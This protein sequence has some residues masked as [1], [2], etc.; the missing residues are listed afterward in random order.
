MK[1]KK[2]L[3]VAGLL[4]PTC[5]FIVSCSQS[6]TEQ[7]ANELHFDLREISELTISYDEEPLTFFRSDTGELIIKEYMTESKE[8]YY[9][10]VKQGN[11]SIQISEGGKP[12]FRGGFS[13]YVEVYMP[14]EYHGSLSVTST[15][16]KIDLSGVDL[17]LASLRIDST[18]G[19]VL[20][21][22]ADAADIHLSTTS[23]TLDLGS[24]TGKQI[25]LETTSGLIACTKLNGAVTYT[26]TSGDIDVKSAVGSGTYR[27]NNS[28]KLKVAYSKVTGDLSFFN[29]ND[30]IDLTLPPD[31]AFEFEAT[32]KN[33]TVTTSFQECTSIEGQTARGT[34]GD[35]PAVTVKTETKNGNIQVTQ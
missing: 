33:G 2:T 28:G 21:D 23:G 19:T 14:E 18:A 26:S 32:T 13:R 25:R 20:L 6:H 31:L 10:D 22:S 4:I 5:L 17:A 16:G 9:A 27:A 29:K 12:F 7:A 24:I 30:S 15:D 1:T 34:V 8:R 35:A 11:G 3:L